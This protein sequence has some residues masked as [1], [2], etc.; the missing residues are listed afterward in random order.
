MRWGRK[1]RKGRKEGVERR[2][3]GGGRIE[4]GEALATDSF[5]RVILNDQG[6]PKRVDSFSFHRFPPP[7]LPDSASRGSSPA[8]ES[9]LESWR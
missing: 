4:R 8:H 7:S 3:R 2:H 5:E 6:P 1:G 9:V